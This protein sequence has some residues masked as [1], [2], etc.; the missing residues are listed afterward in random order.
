MACA[1][2]LELA[3]ALGLAATS[4]KHSIWKKIDNHQAV[5]DYLGVV[6]TY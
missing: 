2:K 1:A 6:L 3:G 5:G 4:C